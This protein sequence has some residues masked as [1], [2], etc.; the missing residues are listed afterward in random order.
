MANQTVLP[1]NNSIRIDFTIPDFDEFGE[2]LH[3]RLDSLLYY[4]EDFIKDEKSPRFMLITNL[5][6]RDTAR[7][8]A[9]KASG[10][11]GLESLVYSGTKRQRAILEEKLPLKYIRQQGSNWE[12]DA[13]RKGT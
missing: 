3:D 9:L 12:F 11:L 6:D 2:I 10:A 7:I 5:F 8:E 4:I 13:W 1:Q